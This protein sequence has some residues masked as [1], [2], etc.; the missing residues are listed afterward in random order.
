MLVAGSATPTMMGAG[1]NE[2]PSSTKWRISHTSMY[3]THTNLTHIY[4]LI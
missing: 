2:G 1:G 3:I 4:V